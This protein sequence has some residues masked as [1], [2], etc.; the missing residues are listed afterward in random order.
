M[1]VT[2]I[3]GVDAGLVQCPQMT[4]L[5]PPTPVCGGWMAAPSRDTVTPLGVVTWASRV[6]VE[7]LVSGVG[8]FGKE[9]RSVLRPS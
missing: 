5:G 6:S 8:R 9:S 2:L 1:T 7:P 4:N 3:S